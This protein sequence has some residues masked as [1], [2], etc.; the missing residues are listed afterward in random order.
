MEERGG[1]AHG[2]LS[3]AGVGWSVTAPARS[4]LGPER[5]AAVGYTGPMLLLQLD[6][7]RG[8]LHRQIYAELRARILDG[9]LAPGER[10]PSTRLLAALLSVGR[11][12]VLEAFEML[13]AE[14][15]LVARRGSGTYV[16]DS[17]PDLSPGRAAEPPP[18][19]PPPPLRLSAWA[20][21][22]LSSRVQPP[23]SPP[24]EAR[25]GVHFRSGL[26]PETPFPW[27]IWERLARLRLAYPRV[28]EFQYGQPLGLPELREAI[29]SHVGRARGVRCTAEQVMVTSGSQGVL[30]FTTRTL[31]NPG[32]A[33]ALE[34][35]GYPG[36]SR[37][38]SASGA[39][40][41]P[42]PVDEQGLQPAALPPEAR[43]LY[44]TPSHQ[45]PTGA[46]LPIARRLA[47]LEWARR[48]GAWVLEDDYDSEYRYA[49][50]P[51]AALQGLAPERVIYG[52]TLSK[53]LLP[54][55]RVGFLIAPLELVAVLAEIRYAVD[56]QPPSLDQQLTADF[57]REGHFSRHL[58]RMRLVHG[59]RR[60]ALLGALRTHLPAW[61][62]RD[63]GAGLHLYVQ[64]PAGASE[65]E[66]IRR[67][68][69]A[70]IGLYGASPYYLRPEQAPPGLVLGYAHLPPDEIERQVARLGAALAH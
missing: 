34:E 66:V 57:L 39:R 36:A 38:F 1:L 17:L 19:G 42:V 30:D 63:S 9:R 49:G 50:R 60:R 10:L 23:A 28:A 52:G 8:P 58:R 18:A 4:A 26:L 35:P 13:L 44:L 40:L 47:I 20:E 2:R 29:A 25:L 70:G 33:V 61:S 6:P 32:D 22:A 41:V 62:W 65:A 51:L 15:Y 48:A 68:A 59:E 45:Y 56:R 67:A 21:R 46:V 31:L 5:P 64:L 27:P 7:E 54:G 43:L 53:A 12:T 3:E 37:A 16:T 69:E 14:G 55:F 11:N 24:S